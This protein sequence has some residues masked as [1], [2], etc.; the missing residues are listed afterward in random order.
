VQV[1]L[2]STSNLHSLKEFQDL[3]VKQINGSNIRLSDVA[4]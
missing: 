3:I 1:T 2:T 4:E